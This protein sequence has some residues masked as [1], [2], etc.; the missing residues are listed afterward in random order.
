VFAIT[1]RKEKNVLRKNVTAQQQRDTV[2]SDPFLYKLYCQSVETVEH[3]WRVEDQSRKKQA[4]VLEIGAAGGITKIIRPEWLTLDVRNAEGVDF[5]IGKSEPWPILDESIDVI[6]MQ[7]VLHHV[8]DISR[9]A[10]EIN[11]VLTDDGLVVC[12]E[13]YWSLFA[14]I[15][16]RFF[17][18][19]DFSIRRVPK[20]LSDDFKLHPMEGNQAIA[21]LLCAPYMKFRGE[22]SSLKVL[23]ENFDISRKH[24]TNSI[25]FLLSG[26]S[27]FTTRVNRS[28]LLRLHEFEKRSNLWNQLF[29]FS[30]FFTLKKSNN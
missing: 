7:D 14:Q 27:N 8:T 11:R 4:R 13:P 25:A 10:Q 12:R 19:E 22:R 24:A 5:V 21:W 30:F 1:V 2:E 6:F 28:F 3:L 29:G 23:T 20:F 26:G 15:V 16:W 18:P 17:H 9:L